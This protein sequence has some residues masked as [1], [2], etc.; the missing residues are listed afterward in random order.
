MGLA[1]IRPCAKGRTQGRAPSHLQW[2]GGFHNGNS[3]GQLPEGFNGVS[4]N[5][6]LM[7]CSRPG[8]DLVL[9]LTCLIQVA[10]RA[11]VRFRE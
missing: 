11:R 10:P 2:K 9:P 1:A 4:L 5:L 7:A 3:G 6:P 8:L